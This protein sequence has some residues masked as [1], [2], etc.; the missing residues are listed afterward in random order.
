MAKYSATVPTVAELDCFECTAS[1][2]QSLDNPS[3]GYHPENFLTEQAKDKFQAR[4]PA[5]RNGNRTASVDELAE[6]ID[7]F[8]RT[9]DEL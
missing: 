4:W 2:L 7:N 3:R 1:Y 6:M 9:R 8:R 5:S